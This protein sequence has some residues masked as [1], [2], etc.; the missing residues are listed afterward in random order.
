MDVFPLST[1]V[2]GSKFAQNFHGD[3]QNDSSR[4]EE[5]D[6]SSESGNDLHRQTVPEDTLAVYHSCYI[7]LTVTSIVLD[8]YESLQL[9][10]GTHELILER[11]VLLLEAKTTCLHGNAQPTPLS[12]ATTAVSV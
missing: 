7:L 11:T 3:R 10:Y 4:M 1:R 6:W 12:K 8:K 2:F 9:L 5:N